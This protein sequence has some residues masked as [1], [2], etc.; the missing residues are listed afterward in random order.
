M[1]SITG[2]SLFRHRV[3]KGKLL[4]KLMSE[5]GDGG[6]GGGEY[7]VGGGGGELSAR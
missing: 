5:T 7:V 2:Q 4:A 6:I 1:T 3:S